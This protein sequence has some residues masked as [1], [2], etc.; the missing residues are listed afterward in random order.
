MMLPRTSARELLRSKS[1]E[2]LLEQLSGDPTA[3]HTS[4]DAVLRH[5]RLSQGRTRAAKGVQTRGLRADFG[6]EVGQ[7]E[8]HYTLFFNNRPQKAQTFQDRPNM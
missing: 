1:S 8:V 4:R 6:L 3:F 5:R 7:E 2:G